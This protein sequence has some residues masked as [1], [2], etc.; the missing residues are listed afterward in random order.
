MALG[1]KNSSGQII[2]GQF[3]PRGLGFGPA[4]VCFANIFS[5]DANAYSNIL[6]TRYV[7]NR[8]TSPYVA[9][10]GAQNTATVPD[11]ALL[12]SGSIAIASTGLPFASPG[13]PCHRC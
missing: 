10:N 2:D 5:N 12:D 7:S 8:G 3:V 11:T 13:P 6:R 9:S 4:E 1:Q